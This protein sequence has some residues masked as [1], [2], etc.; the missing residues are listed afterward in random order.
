MKEQYS[1][2]E[3][4]QSDGD[5]VSQLLVYTQSDGQ[6]YFSCDRDDSPD[7]ATN[8]ATILYKLSDGDLVTE[9]VSSLESQCVSEDRMD[10]FNKIS[11]LISSL[12]SLKKQT[13]DSPEDDIVVDPLG[14][15]NF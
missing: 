11:F 2:E 14:A 15:T 9:I 6:I 1:K 4:P 13:E 10:D 12:R 5:I 7:A 3:S 8:I